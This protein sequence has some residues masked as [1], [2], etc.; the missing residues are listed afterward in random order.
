MP[1]TS[2]RQLDSTQRRCPWTWRQN[3]Q[4]HTAEAPRVS[5]V[6]HTERGREWK[7]QS[8][9][10]ATGWLQIHATRATKQRC[11]EKRSRLQVRERDFSDAKQ[12]NR[13]QSFMSVSHQVTGGGVCRRLQRQRR[14]VNHHVSFYRGGPQSLSGRSAGDPSP[15]TATVRQQAQLKTE[16]KKNLIIYHIMKPFSFLF[17]AWSIWIR[18]EPLP[19]RSCPS[20]FVLLEPEAI[21]VWSSQL[22]TQQTRSGSPAE[23]EPVLSPRL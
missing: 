17:V 18:A 19:S 5:H 23:P 22:C 14:L 13:S 10:L 16:T 20:Q 9:M 12:K 6:R 21:S 15:L 2:P 7:R 3:L 11:E 1:H 8:Y 4:Q